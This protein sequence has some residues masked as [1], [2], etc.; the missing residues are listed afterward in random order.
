[1]YCVLRAVY[2]VLSLLCTAQ[3]L[4]QLRP[5]TLFAIG[6][7]SRLCPV[8]LMEQVRLYGDFDI[9]STVYLAWLWG[10]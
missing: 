4:F 10:V 3:D 7:Q 5:P 9:H 2:G 8:S 1:M 6:S